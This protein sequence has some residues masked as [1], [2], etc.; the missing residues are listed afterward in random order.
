VAKAGGS[1]Q[2]VAEVDSASTIRGMVQAGIGVTV[3]SRS[4]LHPERNELAVR[5]I[6]RPAL[7]RALSLCAS[8]GTPTRATTR[9]LELLEETALGLV[10][11]G[12]W[13][14]ATIP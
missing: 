6:V 1:L 8:R 2:V 10:R 3:M 13:K 7:S 9:V 12:I 11:R 14:G 4:A 5:R